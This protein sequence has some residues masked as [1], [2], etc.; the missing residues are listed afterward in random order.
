MPGAAA[1]VHQPPLG[2]EDDP[3]PVGEDDVVDLWLDLL[4]FVL[5]YGGDVDLVVE[6]ADVADDGLVLHLL[7]V[8][9]RDHMKIPGSGDEDVRLVASVVHG[10]HTVDRK[11]TRLN[12][13][14]RTISYAVF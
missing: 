14:H 12:S 9:V 7:H 8:I 3:L 11:S 5:L 1:Q 4:P 6:V 10:H 2:E 13:S